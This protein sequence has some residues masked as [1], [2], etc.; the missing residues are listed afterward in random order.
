MR[1]ELSFKQN[2]IDNLRLKLSS[3]NISN[4]EANNKLYIQINKKQ[5]EVTNLRIKNSELE[6]Q[7]RVKINKF[8]F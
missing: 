6:G 2:E 4:E 5:E 3:K 8:R 1:K 7:I